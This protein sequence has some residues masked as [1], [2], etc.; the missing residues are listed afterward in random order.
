HAHT[1]GCTSHARTRNAALQPITGQAFRS[2]AEKV[3]K[4]NFFKYLVRIFC[5]SARQF[6][7]GMPARTKNG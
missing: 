7:P 5:L 1:L 6:L 4:L 3:Q 2:G